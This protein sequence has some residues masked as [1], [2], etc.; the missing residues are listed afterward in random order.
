MAILDPI[1][2]A[3]SADDQ[4]PGT[5]ATSGH[6]A[7]NRP[8]STIAPFKRSQ[9]RL[10]G[11]IRWANT[12]PATKSP[13]ALQTSTPDDRLQ[14]PKRKPSA[15]PSAPGPQRRDRVVTT[16]KSDSPNRTYYQR[17]RAQGRKDQQAL[18][19]MAGRRVDVLR[20]LLRD[21]RP[22]QIEPPAPRPA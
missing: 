14:E 15:W 13:R 16:L 11:V 1:A 18:T 5:R 2:Y 7:A 19:F 8:T 21:N 20:A 22:F 10:I 3:T 4:P 12:A 9:Y 17:N 6:Y